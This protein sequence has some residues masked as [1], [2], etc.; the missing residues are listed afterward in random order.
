MIPLSPLFDEQLIRLSFEMPSR[1]RLNHGVEKVVM[2]RAYKNDLPAPIIHRPKSGMRVPVHYWF[3]NELRRY[4]R[5]VLSPR[6]VRSVGIFDPDRVKQL[7]AYDI[8]EG[9]GRYG[10]R[11]WMLLT[12]E[13][14]R[15]LVIDGEA[16]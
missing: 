11:I 2:K 3:Q 15:R 1:L 9:P 4:A 12:F 13:I 5:K 8:E 7:L 14:W 16:V 10:I 6:Q